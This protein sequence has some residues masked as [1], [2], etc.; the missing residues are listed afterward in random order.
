MIVVLLEKLDETEREK[1]SAWIPLIEEHAE[2]LVHGLKRKTT[3]KRKPEIVTAASLYDALLEYES[4]T[5]VRYRLSLMSETFGLPTCSINAAWIQLFNNRATLRKGYSNPV[6]GNDNYNYREALD[7]ILANITRAV[8]EMTEAVETY[9]NQIREQARQLLETMDCTKAE[10]YES[11]LVAA[12][13]IYAA[14]CGFHGKRR[15]QIS[16]RDLSDFCNY[17][18]SMLSKVWL[19]LF[20]SLVQPN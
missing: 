3:S 8:I 7:A 20:A 4:R 15:I 14:I 16:Q 2:Q 19:G 11:V 6:N 13:A 10:D 12:A 9:V 17:S 1:M 5:H 18:P